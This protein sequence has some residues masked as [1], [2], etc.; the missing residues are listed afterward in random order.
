ME[1]EDSSAFEDKVNNN[2]R[3]TTVEPDAGL[4][5][6]PENAVDSTAPATPSPNVWHNIDD[7][8]EP[9]PRLQ[10]AD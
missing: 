2:S 9:A 1:D 4:L 6:S 3:A 10:L 8:V 5:H 7:L